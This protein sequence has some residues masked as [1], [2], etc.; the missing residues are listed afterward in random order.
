MCK[1][2]LKVE[3]DGNKEAVQTRNDINNSSSGAK[4]SGSMVIGPNGLS[5]ILNQNSDENCYFVDSKKI[6]VSIKNKE[7]NQ[8]EKRE[9]TVHLDC[10]KQLEQMKNKASVAEGTPAVVGTK[11]PAISSVDAL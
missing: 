2:K 7:T 8:L 6:R 4:P 9:V 10:L 1:E 11:R 5:G 3:K